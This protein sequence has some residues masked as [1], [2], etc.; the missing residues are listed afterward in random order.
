MNQAFLD[1][2]RCPDSSAN[3]KLECDR[4]DERSP[5]YFRFG[6]DL[7]CYGRVAPS[8]GESATDLLP[9]ALDQVRNEGGTCILPFEP[10]DVA[11]NLRLE[12][13]VNRSKPSGLKGLIRKIYYVLRPAFPVSVRRHLQ[14]LWLKGWDQKPFPRWPVDRTVDQMFETLMRLALQTSTEERI[15][16]IWFWPEAKLSCAIMTHDVE[17]GVGLEFAGQLMDVNDSFGIKSSFQVIPD[18]RYV[19]SKEALSTIQ[20]RGFEVNIHDLKH[21]G[22][23]YDEQEQFRRSAIRIN[24]FATSFGSKGFRS[25]VL[26]RNQEWYDAFRFSYDMSVPNVG[27]LDPQPGGCCTVMPYF[28]GDIL[29]IPVTTTQDYTLFNVFGT[30]S[31]DLWSKQISLIVQQHGLA[32]FIVHPDYLDTAKAMRAYTDLLSHLSKLRDDAGLWVPL[33][34]EVDTWWRQ[35]SAMRLVRDG[36]GW[37]IEGAGSERATIAYASLKNGKVV[38]TFN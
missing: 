2:Y 11:T 33:P 16:F 26:Y 23:L 5:S 36:Q 35:R 17:T 15:P 8:G 28:I 4:F 14:R 38:Y 6:P 29:E 3:F 25:G 22:H 7:I 30:Y 34:G 13:Y 10:D 27:H 20:R 24:E 32:S 31:Q 19:A 18:A 21:D 9:D 1:Y 37:R 12:R